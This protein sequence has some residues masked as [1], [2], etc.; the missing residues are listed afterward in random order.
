MLI[1]SSVITNA[2]EDTTWKASV[3]MYH[4]VDADLISQRPISYSTGIFKLSNGKHTILGYL[5][6]KSNSTIGGLQYGF[7]Y[8]KKT[9]R[10][11]GHIAIKRSTALFYPSLSLEGNFYQNVFSST[12][13]GLGYRHLTYNEGEK[14]QAI[15]GNLTFYTG[16]WMLNYR[17]TFQNNK[18]L[19]HYAAARYWISNNDSFIEFNIA[20]TGDS[21]AQHSFDERLNTSISYG[22]KMGVAIGTNYEIFAAYNYTAAP[23]L[24][25][26]LSINTYTAG[27]KI[28]L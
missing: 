27:I 5:G 1:V 14:L 17:M 21:S 7:D 2:Q 3:I 28:N 12:T 19:F 15:N 8:Y 16:K 13:L 6:H 20:N 18:N 10:G 9:K 24:K 22:A 23:Y 11:Y 25:G 4:T 26:Q